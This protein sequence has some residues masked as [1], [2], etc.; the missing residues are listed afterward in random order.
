MS[1]PNTSPGKAREVGDQPR[2]VRGGQRGAEQRCP[3]AHPCA[4]AAEEGRAQRGGVA[5]ERVEEAVHDDDGLRQA[6]DQQRLP[7]EQRLQHATS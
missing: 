5:H 7:A 4:E 6:D 3:G 1:A 2:G